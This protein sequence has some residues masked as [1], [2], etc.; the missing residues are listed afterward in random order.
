MTTYTIDK[1]SITAN[2]IRIVGIDKHQARECADVVLQMLAA[3]S[4]SLP[5][6]PWSKE[7]EMME[8]WA[9]PSASLNDAA[10]KGGA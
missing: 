1:D 7:A 10:V 3:P 6:V 4:T 9:A 8:A 5:F 2:L